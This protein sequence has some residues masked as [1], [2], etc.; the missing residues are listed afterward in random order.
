[1]T[2]LR[3]VWFVF[4]IIFISSTCFSA[5][6]EP[7]QPRELSPRQQAIA[8]R[9][10]QFEQ[11]AASAG[12]LIDTE[13][14]KYVNY[15]NSGRTPDDANIRTGAKFITKNKRFLPILT[16]QKNAG[17]YHALSSWVFYFDGKK[18]KAQKQI[19]LGI[20]DSAFNSNFITTAVALSMVYQ[21]YNSVT[22]ILERKTSDDDSSEEQ[23]ASPSPETQMYSQTPNEGTLNL[24]VNSIRYQLLGKDFN[25]GDLSLS[26]DILC[27]LL[28]QVDSDQ[29]DRFAPPPPPPVVD[30]NTIDPN[31]PPPPPEPAPEPQQVNYD[32]IS[33]QP[34]PELA[35]FTNLQNRFS[36]NQKAAF[37]G[38]NFNDPSKS[39]HLENW[40]AKNPQKWNIVP[41]SPMVQ[42]AVSSALGGKPEKPVLLIAGPDSKIR[43]I[44]DV[45]SFLPNMIIKNILEN[46]QTAADSNE[47]NAPAQSP[48][49]EQQIEVLEPSANENTEQQPQQETTAPAAQPQ[50][51]SAEKT[52]QTQSDDQ[53]K[54]NDEFFDPRAE[55]LL[56]NAKAFF[57]IGNRMQY[58]TYAKPIEM[59]RTVIKDYPNTKYADQ[60]RV[61]MRQV[62]ERFRER[63][64]ITDEEL[65][66]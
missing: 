56:E 54:S 64:N 63:Y 58:H 16:K 48:I 35:A 7:A 3:F 59:C 24:D 46:P 43:Y 31:N 1:M 17:T 12:P 26:A 14:T 5:P 13:F 8:E 41:P 18:D 32:S 49:A 60:A 19:A 27:V 2:Y 52:I 4:V 42:Q 21:D 15:V 25:F 57:K 62:P 55:T 34:M 29:L 44:G 47:P 37:I 10:Q 61:L 53:T 11:D 23:P 50:S 45:N 51:Q 36:K 33:S 20:K 9:R 38:I 30:Q 65:G 22:Q 39:K 28:W 6:R 66:L 40:I